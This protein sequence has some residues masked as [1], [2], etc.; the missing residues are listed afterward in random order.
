VKL[1]NGTS[2]S[3]PTFFPLT[4]CDAA[5]RRPPPRRSRARSPLPAAP[6]WRQPRAPARPCPPP[7]PPPAGRPSSHWRR[8]ARWW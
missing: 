8:R 1:K 5:R 7:P 3:G 2:L 6:A 4:K